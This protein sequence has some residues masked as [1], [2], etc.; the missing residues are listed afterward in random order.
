M[1]IIETLFAKLC[2]AMDRFSAL[3]NAGGFLGT[4]RERELNAEIE[5]LYR[6]IAIM[7]ATTK[8]DAPMKLATLLRWCGGP[9]CAWELTEEIT[10]LLAASYITDMMALAEEGEVDDLGLAA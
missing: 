9:L 7:P 2:E 6:V 5:A 10:R 8:A 4:A 1:S 3:Q